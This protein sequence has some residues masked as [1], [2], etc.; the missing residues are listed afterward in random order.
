M[1]PIEAAVKA[2]NERGL[3]IKGKWR[4]PPPDRPKREHRKCIDCKSNEI[5]TR[6]ALKCL[7]LTNS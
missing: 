7:V 4:F 6:K 3:P 2:A 5:P 1:T